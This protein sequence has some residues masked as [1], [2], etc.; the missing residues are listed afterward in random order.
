MDTEDVQNCTEHGEIK[1]YGQIEIEGGQLN[2]ASDAISQQNDKHCDNEKPVLPQNENDNMKMDTEDSNNKDTQET[3][4][5]ILFKSIDEI[6][7]DLKQNETEQA[8]KRS[9]CTKSKTK[10]RVL[11]YKS[12]RA[13]KL[14]NRRK[15]RRAK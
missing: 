10:R 11:S 1:I 15:A 5:K 7:D 4:N 6:I 14:A 9:S 8:I 13:R 12:R 2:T 3:E